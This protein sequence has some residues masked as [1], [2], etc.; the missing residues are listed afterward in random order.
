MAYLDG[1]I[2]SE[3]EHRYYIQNI[4]DCLRQHNLN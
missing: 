2:I 1:I 4:F 3:E